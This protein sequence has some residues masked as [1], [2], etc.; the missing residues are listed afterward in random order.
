[1]MPL[2]CRLQSAYPTG[3]IHP[4]RGGRRGGLPGNDI[5]GTRQGSGNPCR[6]IE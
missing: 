4:L 3:G 1:M 5:D 6:F 2:K